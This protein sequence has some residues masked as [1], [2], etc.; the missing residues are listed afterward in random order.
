MGRS[1]WPSELSC[2]KLAQLLRMRA[3]EQGCPGRLGASGSLA[4]VLGETMAR[5]KYICAVGRP[6]SRVHEIWKEVMYRAEL[7]WY[8]HSRNV[9]VIAP[10]KRV[11]PKEEQTCLRK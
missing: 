9:I 8:W 10:S 6:R 4:V 3:E 5:C 7:R 2:S 1:R 11:I